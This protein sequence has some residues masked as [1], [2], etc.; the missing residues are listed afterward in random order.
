MSEFLPIVS[1]NLESASFDGSSITVR[2]KAGTAYRYKE[3]DKELW[4]GFC[5]E[6]DGKDGHSAG[7]F[8][9]R[10]IKWREY[11]QVEDWK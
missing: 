3:C 5:R 1:S 9:A 10:E 2:F 11:E 6:F 4:T 7:K 8:F